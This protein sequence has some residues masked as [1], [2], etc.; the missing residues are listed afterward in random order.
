MYTAWLDVSMR[1]GREWEQRTFGTYDAEDIVVEGT[2]HNR[3]LW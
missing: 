1:N 3:I 2:R